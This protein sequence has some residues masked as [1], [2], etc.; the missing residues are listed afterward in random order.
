MP[1]TLDQARAAKDAALKLFS[2]VADVVG[3]G[4]TRVGD[5][6]GVKV[7]L[8]ERPKDEAK[9]PTDVGGVPVKVDVVGVIRKG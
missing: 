4:I 5:G 2:A 9:L 3:V 6:Y 8:S 7:N 1:V